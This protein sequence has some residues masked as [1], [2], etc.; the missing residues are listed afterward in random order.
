MGLIVYL[1]YRKGSGGSGDAAGGYRYDKRA[2]KASPEPAP[3]RTA[4]GRSVDLEGAYTPRYSQPI[5]PRRSAL[6]GGRE[7]G[8]AAA[9]AAFHMHA[10]SAVLPAP[11]TP[12]TQLLPGVHLMPRVP[13]GSAGGG[14]PHIPCTSS[15]TSVG[16]RVPA[17]VAR[18]MAAVQ[19]MQVHFGNW[20]WERG[21]AEGGGV[22]GGSTKVCGLAGVGAMQALMHATPQ[23]QL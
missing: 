8:A 16:P 18:T 13:S 9:G 23:V 14:A 20:F 4:S 19:D 22:G 3:R 12:D 2:A 6:K 5:T 15:A 17:N 7:G 10:V 1:R 11:R 21:G